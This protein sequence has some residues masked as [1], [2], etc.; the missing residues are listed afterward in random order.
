MVKHEN[1]EITYSITETKHLWLETIAEDVE[2][3]I[4]IKQPTINIKE[5]ELFEKAYGQTKPDPNFPICKSSWI[6]HLIKTD[7]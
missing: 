1:H 2:V 3:T 7:N 6:S 5:K 4:Q